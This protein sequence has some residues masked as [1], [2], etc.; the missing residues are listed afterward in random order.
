MSISKIESEWAWTQVEAMA[1]GGLV[2]EDLE[3]M[4]R[5]LQADSE[6]RE[7]LSRAESVLGTLRRMGT[8]KPPLGLFLRLLARGQHESASRHWYLAP[9]GVA[10]VGVVG[11]LVSSMLLRPPETPEQDA[12]R[13]FEIAMAYLRQTAESTREQV[14]QHIGDGL[15][16]AMEIGRK[17]L[18]KAGQEDE[19]DGG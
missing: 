16:V 17:T 1:D 13:D 8:A 19:Q 11:L 18:A 4:H 14:G 15:V 10:A 12:V 5:V 2:G 3:R 7:A 9:A 6:L